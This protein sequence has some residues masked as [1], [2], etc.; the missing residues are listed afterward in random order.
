MKIKKLISIF[1]KKFPS[2]LAEDWD[3]VGLCVGE[4][5][6]EILKVQISLDITDDVIENAICNGVN[7]IIT[8]HPMIFKGIKSVSDTTKTGQQIIKLIKNGISVYTMHT[9][10]DSA[11]FGL[12]NF[13]AEKIGMKIGKIMDIKKEKLLKVKIYIPIEEFEDFRDKIIK[14]SYFPEGEYTKVNYSTEYKEQYFYN[15]N[16][17]NNHVKTI[18]ILIEER[19][20][21]DLIRFIEKNHSYKEPAYE[22]SDSGKEIENGGIGRIFDLEEE[23]DLIDYAEFVKNNLKIENIRIIYNKNK[24][25]K[26]I[27]VVNGSGIEY[28]NMARRLGADVFVTSDVKYHDGRAVLDYDMAVIDIGHFEGEILFAEIISK[29]LEEQEINT[30]IYHGEPVFK[31]M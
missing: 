22:I 10:L 27:A 1:E 18:E 16:F 3:N 11:K 8:H 5:N 12:N 24:K 17:V 20:K 29:I 14:E 4:G 28:T 6:Q 15:G 7:L 21:K 31:T 30:I 2:K 19:Y 25:I 9:N 13:I 23:M 26:K